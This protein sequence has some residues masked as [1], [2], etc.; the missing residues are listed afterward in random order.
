M[1]KTQNVYLVTSFTFWRFSSMVKQTNTSPEI[2]SNQP[3]NRMQVENQYPP[4]SDEPKPIP[5]FVI[6]LWLFR[7]ICSRKHEIFRRNEF[8]LKW[9]C[10]SFCSFY[11]TLPLR[12]CMLTNYRTRRLN[13]ANTRTRLRHIPKPVSSYFPKIYLSVI[14]PY[15]SLSPKWSFSTRFLH[16]NSVYIPWFYS[17]CIVP[18]CPNSVNLPV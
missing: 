4:Y 14:F 15:P 13:N 7:D 18:S 2:C 11:L 10:F 17:S 9:N 3:L 1:C 6:V 12:Y 16:Q 8:S 5:W